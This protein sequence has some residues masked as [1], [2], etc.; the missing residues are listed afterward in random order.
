MSEQRERLLASKPA[1]LAAKEA[2]T[3]QYATGRPDR[4]VGLGL[5]ETGE[6]WAVKVFAHSPSAAENLPTTF[7]NFDVE[8][9]VAKTAVSY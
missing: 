9:S 7:Q 2:F 3:S 4:S 8:V 5:D 6:H 1:A